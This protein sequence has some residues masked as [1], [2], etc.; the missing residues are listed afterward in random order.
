M[1]N[2][3]SFDPDTFRTEQQWRARSEAEV[4]RDI[5]PEPLHQMPTYNKQ[6]QTEY[7]FDER[8]QPIS[9]P[10]QGRQHDPAFDSNLLKPDP[11]PLPSGNHPH[12]QSIS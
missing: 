2:E 11:K 4:I 8:N 1:D 5:R 6:M 12:K 7:R 10:R 9:I 3:T